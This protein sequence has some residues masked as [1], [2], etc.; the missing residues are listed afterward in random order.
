MCGRYKK[1]TG[2]IIRNDGCEKQKIKRMTGK[3]GEK[4]DTRQ[5]VYSAMQFEIKNVNKDRHY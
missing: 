3:Q 1:M 2:K 4:K 5:F